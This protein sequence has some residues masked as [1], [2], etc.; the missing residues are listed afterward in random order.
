MDETALVLCYQ[1]P[2]GT[3]TTT[4]GQPLDITTSSMLVS[5]LIQREGISFGESEMKIW[6]ERIPKVATVSGV[7]CASKDTMVKSG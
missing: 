5:Q 4:V 7:G 3:F 1:W 2:T 6:F